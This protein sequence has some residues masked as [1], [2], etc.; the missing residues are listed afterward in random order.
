LA[1]TTA[2]IVVALISA[3]VSFGTTVMTDFLKRRSEE[4]TKQ[5]TA[6]ELV[7]KY[8]DPLLQSA[9]DLQSRIYTVLA[10]ES[11]PITDDDYFRFNTLFLI[12]EFLGWLEIIRRDMQFLDLGNADAT[13]ALGVRLYTIQRLWASTSHSD[14]RY[15]IYRGEQR[16][17]GE[18]MIARTDT[19]R[20]DDP[21][22]EC[23][24]Y[25]SF[26]D[27]QNDPKFAMWFERLVPGIDAMPAERPR[28]LFVLQNS[29]IDL[30]DFL[31]EENTRFASGRN[32]L[33]LTPDEQQLVQGDRLPPSPS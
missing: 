16:A 10:G 18:L 31:D 11:R 32:R 30:I 1:E 13:R 7:A 9:F 33:P 27:R 26:V 28:R 25:A 5:L 19:K 20:R 23:I 22:H 14:D 2:L 17:I 8:R 21:Q 4:R 15:Y 6:Q 24:G 3:G 12:A 29:L